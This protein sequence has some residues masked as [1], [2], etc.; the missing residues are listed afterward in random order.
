MSILFNN[1]HPAYIYKH[2]YTDK[3]IHPASIDI[4][5]YKRN[6]IVN[7]IFYSKIKKIDNYTH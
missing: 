7:K 6:Y 2:K 1:I 5:E 4:L 3:N